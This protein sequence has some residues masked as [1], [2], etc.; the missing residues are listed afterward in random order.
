MTV[1]PAQIASLQQAKRGACDRQPEL[2]HGH[3]LAKRGHPA[4]SRASVSEVHSHRLP[5]QVSPDRY[6]RYKVLSSSIQPQT[7]DKSAQHE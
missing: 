5:V 3:G 6:V 2:E 1:A 4:A 7:L